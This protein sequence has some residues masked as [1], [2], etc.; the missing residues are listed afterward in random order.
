M[1]ALLIALAVC[2]LIL[3]PILVISLMHFTGRPSRSEKI[4]RGRAQQLYDVAVERQR[5]GYT[6]DP[7][8][9]AN[10]SLLLDRLAPLHPPQ[11]PFNPPAASCSTTSPSS[12]SRN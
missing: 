5:T 7:A 4:A 6:R 9:A 3:G 11:N 1:I 12:S 2:G 8:A 10:R